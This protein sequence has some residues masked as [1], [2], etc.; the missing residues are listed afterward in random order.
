MKNEV[1]GEG[2]AK[3]DA[4]ERSLGGG[5]MIGVSAP[6]IVAKSSGRRGGMGA[7]AGTPAPVDADAADG[8]AGP[9]KAKRA[10]PVGEGEVEGA[11]LSDD[12]MED[13][14][15]GAGAAARATS[16]RSGAE[17]GGSEE[18]PAIIVAGAAG[19][20]WAGVPSVRREAISRASSEPASDAG[21]M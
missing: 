11:M 4:P 13:R 16:V 21:P 9:F 18:P 6:G 2:S 20:N 7:N 5:A 15:C 8:E 19:G 1:T 12:A 17:A 14:G 3:N 10:P